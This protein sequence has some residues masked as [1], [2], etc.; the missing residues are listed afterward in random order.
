MRY[1]KKKPTITHMRKLILSIVAFVAIC[2]AQAQPGLKLWYDEPAGNWNEA[3][4]LGNGRLG[5][6]LYGDPSRELLQLNEET[7]WAGG[8]YNNLNPLAKENL[9]EIRSLIFDN[10]F[11]QA[12]EM[13][14]KYIISPTVHGMSYQPVGNLN[15]AFD[16][17][18]T[19]TDY[20]RDLNISDAVASIS[21][22]QDGVTYT[23]EVFVSAPD[24]VIVMRITADKPASIGFT[25]GFDSP[26]ANSVALESKNTLRMSGVSGDQE[27]LAGVVRFNVYARILNEGGRLS[28]SGA[29]IKVQNADAVTILVSA[30]TNFKD[31]KTLT[32]DPAA[33]LKTVDLASAKSY[34]QLKQAHVADYQKYFNRVTLDL[35]RTDAALN[36]TKER[37]R[38][39]AKSD[40]P[41]L[42]ALYFQFGRY[43]LI[44][45]S[46]PGTQ[47]AN[48]QGIWNNHM[49]APWDSKYTININTEMNYWPAEVTNLTEMHS[50]LFGM[51]R[52][53][54]VTGRDAAQ[55]MYGA[56]GWVT[57]HNTDLWRSTGAV[58]RGFYGTWPMGG[59]WLSTHI[60]QHYLYTGDKA[61]LAEHYDLLKGLSEFY[62]DVMVEYPGKGWLVVVPSI[63]PEN[64]QAD[65]GEEAS[66]LTAGATMDNQIVADVFDMTIGAAEQLGRK[67]DAEFVK[68]VKAARSRLAPMQVGRHGQLQEWLW[69]I[70]R[71]ND[72][73]RHVSHLYGMFPSNQISPYRNPELFDAV[74]K[75]LE[76]RGDVSTGWSMGWKVCLWARLLDGNHAFKLITDQLN[77]TRATGTA[78]GG[79]TYAN[80]FDAHPPFQID[81]NFGCTAGIAEML[82]QSHDGA[83]HI[84]P[85]LPDNWKSGSVTGLRVRGGFEVDITWNAGKLTALNVRSS[86]GGNCR[87]RLHTPVATADAKLSRAKGENK[88][89][90]FYVPVV[91]KPIVSAQAPE[92]ELN[93]SPSQQVEFT[94]AA[95]KEYRFTALTE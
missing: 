9:D 83:I 56:K 21:Y 1:C 72:H 90:Y 3:L 2:G 34:D 93:L 73:H 12:Q 89:P 10:K 60:W 36:T 85:A 29:S 52:D 68:K 80:L 11:F 70:D 95:G 58:D 23:R 61:F 75:T 42:V 54:S 25:A 53:L 64:T 8:P 24:N 48:L 5:A 50:P 32:N 18:D 33:A 65:F 7:V 91:K 6:M 20:Y 28:G 35:G 40:D 92:A 78:E 16:G 4:P 44:S 77:L 47:P 30:G 13:A 66:S 63:S 94:S 62:L 84:L 81:G 69:D 88:N 39:F 37:V 15:L 14:T 55:Q 45:A 86:L 67:D 49:S 57:H 51:I 31:Y 46:R 79:G 71:T 17:H 26:Q 76:Y 74:R 41:Q 82:V 19:F 87:L 38:D 59:A 27:G 22:K 43:L